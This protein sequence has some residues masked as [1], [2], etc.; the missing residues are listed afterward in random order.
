[1]TTT[2]VGFLIQFAVLALGLL[3]VKAEAGTALTQAD[4]KGLLS[5][6]GEI[7]TGVQAVLEELNGE[8][9]EIADH[10]DK[11][12]FDLGGLTWMLQR[13][14]EKYTDRWSANVQVNEQRAPDMGVDPTDTPLFKALAES[15]NRSLALGSFCGGK[16]HKSVYVQSVNRGDPESLRA[17]LVPLDKKLTET[18]KLLGKD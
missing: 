2:R 18:S 10:R 7:Q 8:P 4:R 13:A 6:L 17:Q 9:D 16:P 5:A 15:S 14:G 1:M 3:S 11:I 12:C